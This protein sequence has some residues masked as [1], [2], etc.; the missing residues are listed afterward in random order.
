MAF[1]QE[2]TIIWLPADGHYG[3]HNMCDY[4][5]KFHMVH[6]AGL[7]DIQC[8]TAADSCHTMV[9]GLMEQWLFKE[10]VMPQQ[11]TWKKPAVLLKGMGW[12]HR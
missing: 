9:F 7:V 11:E 2:I 5:I 8:K 12:L 1:Q 3:V 10:L 6:L 4:L